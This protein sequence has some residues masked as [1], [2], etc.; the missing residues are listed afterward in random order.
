MAIAL[1]LFMR[2]KADSLQ[3]FF[4]VVLV[5]WMGWVRGFRVGDGFR[6]LRDPSWRMLWQ[7]V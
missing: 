5:E 3:L 7:K 6:V 4:V 1:M 2:S